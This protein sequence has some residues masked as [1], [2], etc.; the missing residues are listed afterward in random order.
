MDY[1]KPDKIKAA[2]GPSVGVGSVL[3][4]QRKAYKTYVKDFNLVAV[5]EKLLCDILNEELPHIKAKHLLDPSMLIPREEYLKWQS[6]QKVSKQ[7]ATYYA[8]SPQTQNIK[9][10]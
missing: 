7:E 9:K 5:R 10:K 3:P 2:F 1:V 8:I 4:T 6:F